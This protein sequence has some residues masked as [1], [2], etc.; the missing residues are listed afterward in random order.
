MGTS[1]TENWKLSPRWQHVQ[2]WRRR[3]RPPTLN[4]DHLQ[5]KR[6]SRERTGTS[7]LPVPLEHTPTMAGWSVVAGASRARRGGCRMSHGSVCMRARQYCTY[8]RP[9][10]YAD[11]YLP[12][13]LPACPH[14]TGTLL[15]LHTAAKCTCAGLGTYLG[16]SAFV[17][18]ACRK[19]PGSGSPH[20]CPD[21]APTTRTP[22]CAAAAAG[23]VPLRE[24]GHG[25][26]RP[27]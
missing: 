21:A 27:L 2:R 7:A 3:L 17:M 23:G 26:Q 20:A 12:A 16:Q 24:M 1:T 14:N 11:T 18:H 25:V 22:P 15:R 19:R 4:T 13:C 10:I 6:S 8:L 9:Y 5:L